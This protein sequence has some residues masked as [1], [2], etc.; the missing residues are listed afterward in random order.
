MPFAGQ[1]VGGEQRGLRGRHGGVDAVAVAFAAQ[2]ARDAR[3][4]LPARGQF[5]RHLQLDALAGHA[6]RAVV[7]AFARVGHELGAVALRHVLLLGAE[8]GDGGVEL[9][10]Q[11]LALEADLVALAGH[12]VEVRAAGVA[13]VLRLEDVGVARVHRVVLA[14]VVHQA[15][16]GREH[17]VLAR[18]RCVG[19]QARGTPAVLAPAHDELERIG[20]R[21]ARGAVVAGLARLGDGRDLQRVPARLGVRRGVPVVEVAGVGQRAGA[22][23]ARLHVA[24]LAVA[25]AHHEFVRAAQQ[26][27]RAGG[28]QVE[29][30]LAELVLEVA[31]QRAQAGAGEAVEVAVQVQ[32]LGV[33]LALP[34]RAVGLEFPAVVELVREVREG[35]G[36]GR[37]PV[38][39]RRAE[40]LGTVPARGRAV[41]EG[42]RQAAPGRRGRP[43][44]LRLDAHAQRGVRREVGIDHAVQHVLA[45]VVHVDEG[46]TVLRHADEAGAHA[47]VFRHRGLQVDRAAAQVPR[48]QRERCVAGEHLAVGVLAHQV[49]R[50]RR[51]AR[52]GEQPGRA[53]HDLDAVVQ[54]RVVG[55]SAEEVGRDRGRH[56]VVL[57]VVD[58]EA[59]RVQVGAVAV[60]AHR[61]HAGHALHGLAERQ[62]VL[63]VDLLARDDGD[64]LR[65]LARRERQPR[66]RRRGARGVGAGAF[67]GAAAVG[68]GRDGDGRERVDAALPRVPCNGCAGLAT[69]QRVAAV[70][71]RHHL[72]AAAR[73]QALDGFARGVAARHGG[74]A[75]P[76]R[77]RR[78]ERQRDAVA[79]REGGE[80]AAQRAGGNVVGAGRGGV[81][82]G[83]RRLRE[84]RPSRAGQAA[85]G[86]RHQG[87]AKDGVQAALCE[88]A[89]GGRAGCGHGDGPFG[90][91]TVGSSPSLPAETKKSLTPGSIYFSKRPSRAP[92]VP[93]A[94]PA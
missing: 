37:V 83:R 71:A 44:G 52:A 46:I 8:D 84:G 15:R 78:V 91:A 75:A 7:G 51:V 33:L 9:A 42:Q 70:G 26:L 18:G 69:V 30:V 36:G 49:H 85:E 59:A 23:M 31:G 39:P 2:R 41:A 54:H 67:G 22:R 68:L 77:Q 87:M 62:Q 16:V 64:R 11:V 32:Q 4:Q 25:D 76:L 80:R 55:G 3:V 94:A 50:G 72:Q 88:R 28:L 82:R 47:A 53:A 38:G 24:R 57:V 74:A 17:L 48:T 56:A 29:A 14:Q 21:Q 63:V 81:E 13:V 5:A 43:R 92:R 61:E 34:V 89:Q 45:A 35:G 6:A 73:E 1:P 79:G 90:W 65:R 40:G 86:E 27:E 60:G 10:V 12:R 93:H 20:Q 19:G 66:G 58:V